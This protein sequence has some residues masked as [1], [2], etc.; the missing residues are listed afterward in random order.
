MWCHQTEEDTISTTCWLPVSSASKRICDVNFYITT[1]YPLYWPVMQPS[2]SLC[3]SDGEMSSQVCSFGFPLM[4]KK[5]CLL[6]RTH[7][8]CTD[9]LISCVLAGSFQFSC[10][11]SVLLMSSDLFC[12]ILEIKTISYFMNSNDKIRINTNT[13]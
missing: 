4:D 6:T 12:F 5:C 3:L 7:F 10:I 9:A 11:H 13:D 2:L 8:T 1:L